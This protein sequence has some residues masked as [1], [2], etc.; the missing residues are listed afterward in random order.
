[1][2]TGERY[3]D[4]SCPDRRRKVEREKRVILFQDFEKASTSFEKREGRGRAKG[5][6]EEKKRKDQKE[7]K[8]FSKKGSS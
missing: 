3:M 5:K 4:D 8:R 2:T 1:M 6:K 7:K